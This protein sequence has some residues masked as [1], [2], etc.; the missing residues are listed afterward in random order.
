MTTGADQRDGRSTTTLLQLCTGG[1]IDGDAGRTIAVT[2]V[3][4]GFGALVSQVTVW[5]AV[6][7]GLLQPAQATLAVVRSREGT[8][9]A[10]NTEQQGGADGTH[11]ERHGTWGT[12]GRAIRNCVCAARRLQSAVW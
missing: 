2:G 8:A 1:D 6:G 11:A 7:A 5:P 4:C 3:V 9:R 12:P 10:C